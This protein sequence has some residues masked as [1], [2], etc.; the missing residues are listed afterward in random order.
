MN[1][2]S[3]LVFVAALLLSAATAR[4]GFWQLDRAAQKTAL[5]QSL[6]EQRQRPVLAL[7][8]LAH[9]AEQ[10]AAQVN[11]ALVLQGQWVSERTVYLENRQMNGRV[12]FY[13]VTPLLLT[14]GS[15]V[16][17]QRV[18]CFSAA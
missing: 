8:E 10:A 14:D 18:V 2:K 13:A 9:S 5:Q 4:L 15:V 16:L 7:A 12:G 1:T 3:W 17:V 6:N 11:R